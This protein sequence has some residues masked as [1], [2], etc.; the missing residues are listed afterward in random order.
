MSKSSQTFLW[1]FLGIVIVLGSLWQ[2]YPLQTAQ[3]RMNK[4]PIEGAT[5]S[6]K[7]VELSPFEENFFKDVNIVKRIYKIGGQYYFVV[8]LDGTKNR[9]PIHDPY[10]CF[11]GEG[12]TIESEKTLPIVDGVANLLHISKNNEKREALFWFS[13]GET[14]YTSLIK[15]WWQTTLRR[16][17]LGYSGPEPVLIMVTPLTSQSVNWSEFEQN[18]KPLF[19]I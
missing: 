10:Y 17:S 2:F 18:F 3:N 6:G 5:F 19:K 8:V 7:E 16:I 4:I 11:R 14:N 12:W 9:H 13:N 15:Y 1:L